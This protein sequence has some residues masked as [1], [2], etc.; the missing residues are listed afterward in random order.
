MTPSHLAVRYAVDKMN[1][2]LRERYEELQTLL[3]EA[4]GKDVRARYRIGRLIADVKGSEQRYGARA[5]KN[6][7]AAL[8]RDEATLYRFALVAEAW[9]ESE[10]ETLLARKT[11]HG[12]PL[13]FSH[14]VELAQMASKSE[15]TEMLE[16]ALA[17]GVSVRELIDAIADTGEGRNDSPNDAPPSIDSLL[18]RVASTCN[19]VQRKI[20]IS[21]RLLSQLERTEPKSGC[22][23]DDLL[24]RAVSSQRAI[25]EASARSIEKL[26]RAR[27][28]LT[29]ASPET[30]VLLSASETKAARSMS[31][32]DWRQTEATKVAAPARRLRSGKKAPALPKVASKSPEPPPSQTSLRPSSRNGG[33]RTPRLLAGFVR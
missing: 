31:A 33:S 16:Y 10:L 27:R 7:A 29:P 6:L 14:L 18:R 24:A 5:V 13:S 9:T 19:A 30:G 11:P 8:G 1:I 4:T 15:R 25:L 32:E 28:R 26:E 2:A 20:E 21:E 23:L 3:A 12:E 22:S 17:Y